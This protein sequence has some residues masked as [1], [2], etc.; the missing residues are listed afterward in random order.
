MSE[1]L[2]GRDA[3]RKLREEQAAAEQPQEQMSLL[4]QIPADAPMD[5]ATITVWNG[6]RFVA[7]DQKWFASRPVATVDG[8]PAAGA[9]IPAAQAHSKPAADEYEQEG[10]FE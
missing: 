9:A 7:M 8:K 2:Y 1:G 5:D 4:A 10:L 3:L 6:K